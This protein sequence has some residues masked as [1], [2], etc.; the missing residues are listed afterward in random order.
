LENA[1]ERGDE[2]LSGVLRCVVCAEGYPILQGVAVLASQGH[3]RVAQE[4]LEV[5]DPLRQAGPHL[6][7]HYGDLLPEPTRSEL[8]RGEFWQRLGDLPGG[9]GLAIDLSASAGRAVLGLSRTSSFALGC[10]GSFMTARMARETLR[11]G[12]ARVRVVE[13]GAFVRIHEVDVAAAGAGPCEIIV[14]DPDLPPVA[15]GRASLVLAANLLERQGDPEG[16]VRRSASLVAPRGRLALASPYTWW[17]EHAPRAR[18]IGRGE[19]PTRDALAAL[20]A[21]C[22]LTVESEADLLLVLR[23]HARLEQVVRPHLIVARR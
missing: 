22:G 15:P 5:E 4:T 6:L 2:I 21:D 8:A 9:D 14:A 18:W 3:R 17:E 23:E 10:E 12:R 13:E 20:L 19:S 1:E 11:T 7:A 16:F